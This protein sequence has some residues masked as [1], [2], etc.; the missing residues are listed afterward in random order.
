MSDWLLYAVFGVCLLGF[1]YLGIPWM[2]GRWL[3]VLLTAK[4]ARARTLVLT[5]DD[6]PGSRLTPKILDILKT[7]NAKATFFVLGRNIEGREHLVRRIHEEGHQICSHGYDHINYWKVFPNRALSDIQRGRQAINKVI[8]RDDRAYPF[9]PPY[10][11][12]NLVSLIHLWIRRAPICYWTVVSGD[13]WPADRRNS[14][15]VT[16]FVGMAGGAVLLMHDFDRTEEHDD[17]VEA[18]VI[19]VVE[20]AL[21][22]AKRKGIAVKTMKELMIERS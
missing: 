17:T 14:K 6:G 12:L 2:Y 22:V 7:H 15:Q 8:E 19:D 3:R 18:Y 5:F 10:G 16:E 21:A 4:T 11:K 20:A 9:R 13:T 1:I